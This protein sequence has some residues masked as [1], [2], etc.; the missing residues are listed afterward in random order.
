MPYHTYYKVYIADGFK[1]DCEE[2]I[3]K[4]SQLD[5]LNFYTF[6]E[7][8]K[9][10]NFPCIYQGRQSGAEIAELSEEVV[11]VA[12]EFML[13]NTSNFKEIKSGLYLV[14]A[15]LTQQPYTNFAWLRLTADDICA[16]KRIETVARR[17][18]QYDV[19]YILGTVLIKHTQYHG[20]ERERGFESTIRKYLEGCTSLDKH[21]LR[22]KG[23]FYQQND[24]LDMIKELG[25]ISRRY[26]QVRNTVTDNMCKFGPSI[27]YINENLATEL[28]NS[29]KNVMN[30]FDDVERSSS[31]HYD[32]VRSIKQKAMVT[33]VNP[34]AHLI[35]AEERKAKKS[36]QK[37]SDIKSKAGKIKTC[38]PSKTITSSPLKRKAMQVNEAKVKKSKRFFT[39]SHNP[40]VELDLKAFDKATRRLH[41]DSDSSSEND[42]DIASEDDT[43]DED[44]DASDDAKLSHVRDSFPAIAHTKVGEQEDC[45]I[46]ILDY[47]A[48][49][50]VP[51][52]KA[53][54][55]MLQASGSA[56]T[57]DKNS[58]GA[59]VKTETKLQKKRTKL[60]LV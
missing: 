22:P 7:V 17:E 5:T 28:H 21:G 51:V 39:E 42:D 49:D 20:T 44:S 9:E 14:Y 26:A 29:L 24:E 30:G 12:K 34:M 37:K 48:N 52:E 4:C 54:S 27:K 60:K 31:E 15:L 3:Q 35:S 58:K 18:K 46:E 55:N 50:Q 56:E 2:L 10:M 19:L 33:S 41:E 23:V 16:V 57:N 13:A 40:H 38:S 11:Y 43:G 53:I 8:W 6:T 1:D 47:A 59:N 45:E 25:I 36:P 32:A